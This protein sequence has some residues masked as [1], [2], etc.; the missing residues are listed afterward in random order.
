MPKKTRIF[1]RS[2]VVSPLGGRACVSALDLATPRRTSCS[3][4]RAAQSW[5]HFYRPENERLWNFKKSWEVWW[6]K[7]FSLIFCL[8]KLG[9]ILR[10]PAVKFLGVSYEHLFLARWRFVKIFFLKNAPD[11]LLESLQALLVAPGWYTH[12]SP[13]IPVFRSNFL[14]SLPPLAWNTA[15]LNFCMNQGFPEDQDHSALSHEAYLLHLTSTESPLKGSAMFWWMYHS[16]WPFKACETRYLLKWSLGRITNHFSSKIIWQKVMT[17]FSEP[18]DE[19]LA[20]LP[21][22]LIHGTSKS[23][24]GKGQRPAKCWKWNMGRGTWYLLDVLLLYIPSL[25]GLFVGT[26]PGPLSP[27]VRIPGKHLGVIWAIPVRRLN[28]V[29]SQAVSRISNLIATDQAN[30][31]IT[32]LP[33]LQS[34]FVIRKTPRRRHISTSF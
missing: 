4:T 12:N 31:T 16:R 24:K 32:V 34:F 10:F 29:V 17:S 2:L 1:D 25:S 18:W 21:T 33:D 30:H 19:Q 23:L 27:R 20:D 3:S 26:L 13:L 6:F 22:T 7:W 8:K 28:S 15:S 5:C 11:H 14:Q 9:V